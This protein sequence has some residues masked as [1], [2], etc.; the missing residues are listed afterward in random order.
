MAR[1][2]L[3]LVINAIEEFKWFRPARKASENRR[4]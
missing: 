3:D 2:N 1:E 4:A